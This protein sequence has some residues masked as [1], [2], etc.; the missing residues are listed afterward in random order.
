MSLNLKVSKLRFTSNLTISQPI[1]VDIFYKLYYAADYTLMQ[2][3]VPIG[4]DGTVLASPLPSFNMDPTQK[5][6]LKATNIFCGFE[7]TQDIMLSPYCP[8][9][10]E[11]AADGSFCF[12]EEIVS[13]TPPLAGENTVAKS[14]NNYSVLG[15]WIYDPGYNV[16]GTGSSSQ[17]SL[18]NSFWKN[19][20]GDG[21]PGN[22]IDGPL[23]RSGLWATTATAD[24]TIGFSVCL[25]IP[26]EKT[27]YIAMGTD[28]LGIVKLDGVEIIHQDP[29]LLGVQ[30]SFDAQVTFKAWHIYPVAINVGPRVLELIGYNESSIAAMGMEIY[31]N[32]AA[33]IAAATS[34][35]DLNVIFSSKDY[36]GQPVVLGSN[37]IGYSCP[38]GFSLRQC[39]SPF[40]CVRLLTTPVLY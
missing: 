36:V 21:S 18:A 39:A 24:Q 7:Y 37:N 2:A 15:S 5:Y 27:Y 20:V 26:E 14:F 29:V 31:N 4:V 35:D 10:Y 8:P 40:D 17:I 25:D 11:M 38:S 34:Y 3:D 9:G 16:N 13:A 19:G 12:Y 28:N 22:T 6:T 33:E 23:N 30:Y 32:T 1:T